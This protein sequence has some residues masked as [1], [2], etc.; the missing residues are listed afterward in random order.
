VLLC[1]VGEP[2][3]LEAILAIDQSQVEFLH[4][5]QRVDFEIDQYPGRKFRGEIRELS[6]ADLKVSPRSLSSKAGG[7]LATTTDSTGRERP[8]S[9]TYQADV[10]FESD[11]VLIGT[12]GTAYVHAGYRTIGYRL[13]RYLH[14]TFRM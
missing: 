1:R 6:V 9:V 13:W 11:D 7:S 5:G 12:R 4:Q 14:Q 2:S 3:R 8:L 10:P